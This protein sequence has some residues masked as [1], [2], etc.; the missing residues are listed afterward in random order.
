MDIG[1]RDEKNSYTELLFEKFVTGAAPPGLSAR[2]ICLKKLDMGFSME[3]GNL[4]VLD[5]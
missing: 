1:A 3:L 5:F 4:S 2:S